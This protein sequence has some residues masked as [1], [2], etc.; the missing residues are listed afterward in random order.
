MRNVDAML[1][2]GCPGEGVWVE[3]KA[4]VAKTGSYKT[5]NLPKVMKGGSVENRCRPQGEWGG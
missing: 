3:R 1:D 2:N 4:L 5:E